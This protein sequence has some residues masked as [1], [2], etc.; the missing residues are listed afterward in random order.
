M[1]IWSEI[2]EGRKRWQILDN[3][4]IVCRK[5]DEKVQS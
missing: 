4:E 5:V 3:E 1:A 2:I